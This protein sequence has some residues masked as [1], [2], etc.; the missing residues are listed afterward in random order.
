MNLMIVGFLSG[1]IGGMGIGGGILLIPALTILFGM[2]QQMAQGINL[3]YFIPTA[4]TAVIIH[5]KNH[6]IQ[7][8]VLPYL[9]ITGIVGSIAG[10]MLAVNI[11][12]FILKKIFAV[13]IFAMG[14]AE[15][16]KK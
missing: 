2:T 15:F 16:F 13:F 8:E 3:I 11:D 6:N 10:A 14:I 5:I 9:I 12:G 1:V 4:I 7:K